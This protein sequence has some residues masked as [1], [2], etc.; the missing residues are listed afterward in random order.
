MYADP[1]YAQVRGEA[2][3]AVAAHADVNGE[4]AGAFTVRTVLDLSTDS[5]PDMVRPFV[6]KR[7]RVSEVQ[8]WSAPADGSDRRGTM[9]LTVEGAPASLDAAME[10]VADPDG[11]T[12]ITIE[13]DLVAKI[14]LMGARLEKAALPYIS[15][16]LRAEERSA[17]A[18]RSRD[19]Q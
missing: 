11:T 16:V 1:Q 19:S 5:V 12:R 15:K 17:A 4:A 6:G 18:Y 2:L 7:L 14:P 10:L 9:K 8:E 13:G 3:R